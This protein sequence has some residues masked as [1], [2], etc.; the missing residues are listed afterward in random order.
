MQAPD[1]AQGPDGRFY[2]YYALGGVNVIS[3]AVS[4]SPAGPFS[5]LEYVRY[6]NQSVPTEGN[7][8]DPAIYCDETGNYLYYGFAPFLGHEFNQREAQ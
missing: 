4:D 1:V 3:V 7:M 5:F 2:L 6:E 8:F